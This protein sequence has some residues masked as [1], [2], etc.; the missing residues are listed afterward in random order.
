M[1]EFSG[2]NENIFTV[3]KE[4]KGNGGT[5]IQDELFLAMTE[6][7]LRERELI[8]RKII[9]KWCLSSLESCIKLKPNKLQLV[10]DTIKRDKKERIYSFKENDANVLYKLLVEILENKTLSDMN[11]IVYKC[12]NCSSQFSA[13]IKSGKTGTPFF[14][15]FTFNNERIDLL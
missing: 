6:N 12:E 3:L 4:V 9:T 13:E 15:D 8:K 14:F 2:E 5:T 7:E 11:Q 1:I 10:F